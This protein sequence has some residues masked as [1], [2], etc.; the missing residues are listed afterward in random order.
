MIRVKA[1]YSHQFLYS[2]IG[3]AL[4]RISRPIRSASGEEGGGQ[5]IANR[6]TIGRQGHKSM[7]RGDRV[8]AAQ[9]RVEFSKIECEN[10]RVTQR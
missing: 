1:A 7:T 9:N 8:I 3:L 6:L 10:T 4:R 2:Q 5:A